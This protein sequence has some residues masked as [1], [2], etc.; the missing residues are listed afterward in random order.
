MQR[1]LIP[2]S[3]EDKVGVAL[4]MFGITAAGLSF[5]FGGD[6]VPAALPIILVVGSAAAL[7][8]AYAL[9]DQSNNSPDVAEYSLVLNQIT[10]MA[11]QLSQ[12]G[13]FLEREKER[14]AKTESDVTSLLAEKDRLEPVVA[15]QRETIE[16]I[17]AAHE[18]R[19]ARNAWKERFYGFALGIVAS[20]VA[21]IIY[22][23]F[24][25]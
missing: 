24:H 25:H 13:T 9:Q 5:G 22:S 14:V 8:N 15:T 6:A 2:P 3:T 10:D 17:L 16:V 19:T 11:K 7:V 12:L 21:S 1:R 4:A 20:V 23:Y 18:N